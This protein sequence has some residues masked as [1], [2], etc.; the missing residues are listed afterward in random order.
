MEAIT[1]G[2]RAVAGSERPGEALKRQTS[3]P[4]GPAK[5]VA[6]RCFFFRD[7]LWHD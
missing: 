4:E 7:A 6:K 1:G 3:H 5:K 2:F